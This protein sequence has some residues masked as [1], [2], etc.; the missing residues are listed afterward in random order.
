MVPTDRG[1]ALLDG[2]PTGS[3]G[4]EPLKSAN[5]TKTYRVEFPQNKSVKD[6]MGGS[7]SIWCRNF[8]ANFGEVKIPTTLTG[9]PPTSEGPAPVCSTANVGGLSLGIIPTLG[10]KVTGE[11][12]VISSK[13]LEVRGL[14]FDGT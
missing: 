14:E 4:K 13:I 5:G 2:P 1:F 12:V 7:I 6:I 10:H 9:L 11:V 8:A 3:C